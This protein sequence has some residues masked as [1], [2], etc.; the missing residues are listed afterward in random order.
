ML[1]VVRKTAMAMRREQFSNDYRMDLADL[2]E[3]SAGCI[4]RSPWRTPRRYRQRKALGGTGSFRID[5]HDT[6]FE[7]NADS[8]GSDS[9]GWG[10][11]PRKL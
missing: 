2:G 5:I 3:T 8:T 9:S 10:V 4:M 6:M 7:N 11:V 1:H